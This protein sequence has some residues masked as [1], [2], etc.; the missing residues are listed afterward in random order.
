VEQ[1]VSLFDEH[2]LNNIYNVLLTGIGKMYA[3]TLANH[4]AKVYIVGRRFAVLEET[5]K[6]SNVRF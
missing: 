1:V 2:L 4:G 3:T 5:A 6:E